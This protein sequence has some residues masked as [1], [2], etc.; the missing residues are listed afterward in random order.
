[1]GGISGRIRCRNAVPSALRVRPLPQ[2]T[3]SRGCRMNRFRLASLGLFCLAA[4]GCVEGEVTYTVNPDGSA[5]VNV[6]VGTL[7]PPPLFGSG[8]GPVAKKPGEETLDDVL[9]QAIRPTLEMPGVA[10]WKDVSAEFLPNG[11]LK[12]AGTAFVKRT[13]DF[14]AQ[15]GIPILNI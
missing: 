5:K 13:A 1:R 12:F 2:P 3:I 15:G 14:D 7:V 9:R 8:G 6:D 11:K 10:A 4:A